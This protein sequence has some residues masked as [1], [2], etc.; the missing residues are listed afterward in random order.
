MARARAAAGLLKDL[1]TTQDLTERARAAVAM[2]DSPRDRTF[3]AVTQELTKLL[4]QIEHSIKQA[5]MAAGAMTAALDALAEET[6]LA[7]PAV[8]V[9][10]PN[11]YGFIGETSSAHQP[12]AIRAVA[13]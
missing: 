7:A 11:D 5:T 9:P 6:T 8:N 10:K 13:K 3:E 2:V 1:G 12:A 4:D